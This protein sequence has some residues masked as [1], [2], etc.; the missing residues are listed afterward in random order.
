[1]EP[2]R[3]PRRRAPASPR[4]WRAAQG[5]AHGPDLAADA[6]HVN[7]TQRGVGLLEAG[8]RHEDAPRHDEGRDRRLDPTRRRERVPELA[9]AAGDGNAIDLLA[10]REAERGRLRRV[11]RDRPRAVGVDV[12]DVGGRQPRAGHRG[13]DERSDASPAR[14][15][16]G[17]VKGLRAR[18][19]PAQLRE[20]WRAPLRG[21]A[22]ALDHEEAGALPQRRTLAA[23]VERTARGR[24]EGHERVEP[25]QREPAQAVAAAR[26]DGVD[27]A[28]G[29]PGGREDDGVGA[30][31]AGARHGSRAREGA[32]GPLDGVG[33]SRE[34]IGAQ[35]VER[36]GR[37]RLA[38]QAREQ[39]LGLESRKLGDLGAEAHPLVARVEERDGTDRPIA[40]DERGPRRLDADPEARREAHPRDPEAVRHPPRTLET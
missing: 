20:R 13:L 11:V 14:L 10:E 25:A 8:R 2:G 30:A 6:A 39:E 29:Q 9:L 36:F 37:A 12:V 40:A 17:D 16:M 33:R 18:R 1:M 7:E 5:R 19:P 3:P 24:V 22:A 35:P 31:R 21:V 26:D 4:A 32:R 34:R 38:V 27:L 23:A 28:G 15:G